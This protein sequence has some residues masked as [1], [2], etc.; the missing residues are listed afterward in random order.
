MT[1]VIIGATGTTGSCLA[2]RLVSD[3]KRVFLVGRDESKL[4]A[5]ADELQAGHAVVDFTSS[6]ALSA[7]V[8][9]FTSSGQQVD[10][11]VNCIGS[12]LLKPAHLTSDAEF[13]DVVETNLF[14][15]FA[16]VRC[17]AKTLR[18]RGGAVV[19]MS[20]AAAKLGIPNHEAI[21]AAKAGIEG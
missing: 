5:L 1:T 6:D 13:R 15:A 18:E 2:R 20:S 16:T 8:A 17:A 11:F 4:Q 7:A 3:G 14:S 21:A 10:S 12:I 9:E 19:L